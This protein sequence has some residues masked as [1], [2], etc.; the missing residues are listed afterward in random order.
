MYS[1]PTQP[2]EP[3]AMKRVYFGNVKGR[4]DLLFHSLCFIWRLFPLMAIKFV[5]IDVALIPDHVAIGK[6]IHDECFNM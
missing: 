2:S 1:I 5:L 3:M 4:S 6:S